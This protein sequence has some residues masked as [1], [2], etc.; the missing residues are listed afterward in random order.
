MKRKLFILILTTTV[1]LTVFSQ[2][3]GFMGKRFLINAEG[4]FSTAFT[5]PN[6]NG[7]NGFFC[8]NWMISPNIEVICHNKGTAGAAFN[9][10]KTM[11]KTT[12]SD[13]DWWE[14]SHSFSEINVL[15]AGV[16]YKQYLGRNSKPPFGTFIKF[17]FDWLRYFYD[18]SLFVTMSKIET[19]NLYCLKLEMGRDYL[20]FNRL[21]VSWGFSVGIPLYGDEDASFGKGSI[22]SF[23]EAG[24][25]KG[26][27]FYH[28]LFGFKVG[29]GFLAF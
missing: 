9:Y 27:V 14:Q 8:Y 7:N 10:F 25:A 17:Q 5:N 16:F 28:Y 13:Y 18:T 4:V 19:Y 11:F 20:F 23:G 24:S 6:I 3:L 22:F 29:V 15:G 1:S 2:N 21:R 12:I 26:R